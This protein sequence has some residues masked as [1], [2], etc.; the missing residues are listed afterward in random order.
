MKKLEEIKQELKAQLEKAAKKAAGPVKI[1]FE[2]PAD[3]S[4]G[5][6]SCN[7]AL[8]LASL[9]KENPR[10]IAEEIIENIELLDEIAK[11]EVAG[12]GFINF[13]YADE[14][15]ISQLNAAEDIT[16][17]A[18]EKGTVL[19]DYSSP[20][21]AK[22]LGVHHLLSTVIGQ[23]TNNILTAKGYDVK[24]LNYL[25]DF[26]TQFGKIIY[27]IKKWGD[28]EEIEKY[29][30]PKL[31]E[32][33]V[34]FHDEE[35][36]DP[37]LD[38][39]GQEE[40]RKLEEGD[41]ENRELW[42]WVVKL[43][44]DN[45]EK[46]YDLLGG[47]HFDSYSGEADQEKFL[48]GVLEEGKKQGVITEGEKGAYIIDLEKDGIETP[49]LVQ[50]ADGATLY[51]TRDISAIRYR[52]KEYDPNKIIYVVDSAQNL[53]F[54]QLFA[55]VK[56]FPWF[57]ENVELTHLRFGRMRFKDKK[58]STRKGNI[59]YLEEVL[60]EAVDRA[61]KIIEE[62]NPELEEKDEVARIVGIGSV[63]YSILNQ[64]PETDIIFDWDKILSFEGNSAPY[65]QYS[66]TRASSI[67][68]QVEKVN[69]IDATY[70]LI[71]E[72]QLLARTIVRF[73]EVVVES[74][75]RLKPNIIANYLYELAQIF[76][77][78][79]TKCPVLSEENESSKTA[80]T[81]L[82]KTFQ[83]VMKEGLNLLSGIEVPEK[84]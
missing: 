40:F 15:L 49:F 78:F 44:K 48:D 70:N 7:C 67:L 27:A 63:K 81:R 77:T 5:D 80:R 46:V 84:M 10:E 51:S 43:S 82:V 42:E 38:G 32:L 25:G 28:K 83:T 4:H 12:P 52:I 14:Y 6:I 76:N 61:K 18:T 37:N 58:M 55:S 71:P 26:G 66:C 56:K 24:G 54:K 11:A 30:I 3:P 34:K 73:K 57:K 68:R 74:A 72:E 60:N 20:N 53:H 41:T 39:K 65:L 9:H 45:L 79:Y 8:K 1:E 62:K 2:R 17:C 23:A 59:I 36:S 22:P 29:P 64:S 16:N 75:N 69:K 47:I 35:E 50:K 31:L 13:S 21:I 33:Y 19:I